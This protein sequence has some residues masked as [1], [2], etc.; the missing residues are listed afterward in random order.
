[1]MDSGQ[2]W[3]DQFRL[4]LQGELLWHTHERLSLSPKAFAILC[5]LVDHPGQLVTKTTL[6]EAVWPDTVVGDG[7][8]AVGIAELRKALGDDP[9]APRFIET[10]HRRGY[11]FIRRGYRF[12][13]TVAANATPL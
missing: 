3:F 12:I 2:I 4:D 8:L 1:M 11:R 5:Y 6:F 10:V 9:Q 13:A 7:V